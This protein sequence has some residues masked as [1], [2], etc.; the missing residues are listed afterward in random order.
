ML[1]VESKGK[2][3][4]GTYELPVSKQLKLLIR[5]LLE[6]KPIIEIEVKPSEPIPV[7]HKLKAAKIHNTLLQVAKKKSLLAK[8]ELKKLKTARS[9]TEQQ[10][11]IIRLKTLEKE[12]KKLKELLDKY[13]KI[14]RGRVIFVSGAILKK[15]TPDRE[16][17]SVLMSP[18][19]MQLLLQF[20]TT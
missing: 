6:K 18:D 15:I 8:R 13:E 5:S 20:L 17:V 11:A 9:L 10:K 16:A 1:V 7:E 19:I 12:L 14:C 3:I 4:T 2:K